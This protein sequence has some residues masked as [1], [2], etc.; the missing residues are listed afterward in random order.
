[1]PKDLGRVLR[2]YF[3]QQQL[4]AQREQQIALQAEIIRQ[5]TEQQRLQTLLRAALDMSEEELRAAL[6][7]SNAEKRF[8]AT[9]AVG[10]RRL[11][12]ID[13]LTRLVKDSSDPVRQAARRSHV[14]LSYLQLNPEVANAKPGTPPTVT[15]SLTKPPDFGPLPGA[16]PSART[17]AADEWSQWWSDHGK[18][19]LKTLAPP[20]K[21]TPTDEL[22]DRLVKANDERRKE[23]LKEYG[24]TLGGQYTEAIARAIPHLS[25]DAR[26]EAR[27]ALAARL[28]DRNES[29]LL[30]YLEDGDAEIRRAAALA[31]AMRDSKETVKAVAQLILDPEPTVVRATCA[32]LRSLTGEDYGP[33]ANATEEEKQDAVKKYQSWQPK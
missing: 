30:G 26:K 8:V 25:G 12:W 6:K 17:K 20:A 10:E 4:Q 7:S 18:T 15:A 11:F 2:G 22:A 1:M 27:E 13:D 23:L 19:E 3:A 32:S 28:A 24:N 16:K 21:I 9:Y 29:T 33:P 5:Q 14:I 31:L